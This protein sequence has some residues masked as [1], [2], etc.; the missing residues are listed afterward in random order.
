MSDRELRTGRMVGVIS[1]VSELKRQ[2]ATH[3][4]VTEARVGSQVTL[5]VGE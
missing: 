4:E 1:H 2:I 5:T 3:I